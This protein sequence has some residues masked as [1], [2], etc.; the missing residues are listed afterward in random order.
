MDISR[1]GIR[2]TSD[3]K[4]VALLRQCYIYARRSNHPSTHNAALLVRDG[5]VVCRGLNILPLGVK[6]LP[7][8]YQG[9]NKHIYPNHAERAVIYNAARHGIAVKGLVM[10]MPWLPCIPCAN[11]I[12]TSGVRK[13]VIH[14]Q[15]VERTDRNWRKELADAV[16]IMHEAG[17]VVLAYDGLVGAK[18]YM[19]RTEWKA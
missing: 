18:A 5:R 6:N 8:R 17:I 10:V 11:A 14:R 1:L 16:R 2:I 12:I 9:A 3:Q 4:Y 7:Q 13:L 15:M 19:H